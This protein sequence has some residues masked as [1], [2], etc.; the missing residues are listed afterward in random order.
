MN[1]IIYGLVIAGLLSSCGGGGGSNPTTSNVSGTVADGYLGGAQICADINNNKVCDTGEP[2]T[3]SDNN[4]VWELPASAVNDNPIIAVILPT[5]IDQDTGV[6]VGTKT[7]TLSTPKGQTFISPITT[8]AQNKID[9]NPSLDAT[10]AAKLVKADLGVSGDSAVLYQDYASTDNA[11]STV[12]QSIYQTGQMIARAMAEVEAVLETTFDNLGITLDDDLKKMIQ[13]KVQEK[14]EE[15]APTLFSQAEEHIR[16][17]GSVDHTLAD[18]VVGS[19]TS[20]IEA[21]DDD[22]TSEEEVRRQEE[23]A[24]RD[25]S[26]DT[27]ES[28]TTFINSAHVFSSFDSFDRNHNMFVQSFDSQFIYDKISNITDFLG[29]LTSYTEQQMYD[30]LLAE[31]D[32]LTLTVRA[33][34]IEFTEGDGNK[35][36]AYN[37]A[38]E[39][40][41]GLTLKCSELVSDGLT[42]PNSA[43]N[44]ILTFTADDYQYHFTYNQ[45]DRFVRNGLEEQ[46]QSMSFNDL[47]P[48][49][50]SNWND[51]HCVETPWNLPDTLSS[52]T[53]NAGQNTGYWDSKKLSYFFNQDGTGIE[54]C[55]YDAGD[56]LT[57]TSDKVSLGP[58]YN[59]SLN[60]TEVVWMYPQVEYNAGN[61]YGDIEYTLVLKRDGKYYQVT[62]QVKQNEDTDIQTYSPYNWSAYKK[63]V[64]AL[65]PYMTNN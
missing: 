16:N 34:S 32:T 30:V 37:V 25:T 53:A 24:N 51:Y 22:L 5:T 62:S 65:E 7:Y 6:S 29:T 31:A 35:V 44:V 49:I 4:G 13:K 36:V 10:S 48:T 42:C 57:C 52:A 18:T 50:G 14:I 23:I 47:C 11:N 40:L 27:T 33:D 56:Y 39:S 26:N 9:A 8:M 12:H 20:S 38:K 21:I 64:N 2:T 1:N 60:T 61:I 28:F 55:E 41:N 46:L 58:F 17:G 45:Y 15:L 3:T 54:V 43:Q 59:S 63:I 19:Q